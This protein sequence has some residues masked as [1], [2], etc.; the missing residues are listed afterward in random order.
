MLNNL[1]RPARRFQYSANR[2]IGDVLNT[3]S[4]SL[5]NGGWCEEDPI[6]FL[7]FLSESLCNTFGYDYPGSL[8][9]PIPPRASWPV[10]E[11]AKLQKVFYHPQPRFRVALAVPVL[12]QCC[13]SYAASQIVANRTG[14]LAEVGTAAIMDA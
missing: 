14:G 7:L 8:R 11:A 4:H 9:L 10:A 5:N 3:F 6:L 2:K 13:A 12:C 1:T